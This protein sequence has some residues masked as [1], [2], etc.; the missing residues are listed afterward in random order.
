MLFLIVDRLIAMRT[1]T[2]HRLFIIIQLTALLLPHIAATIP[3][4]IKYQVAH[5]AHFGSGLVGFLLGVGMLGC[6]WPWNSEPCISRKACRLLAFVFLI[7]CYVI[8]STIFFLEETPT[9][10]SILYHS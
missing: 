6:P 2:G 4:I 5:L 10:D 1:N 9:V 8:T 7:L 3:L